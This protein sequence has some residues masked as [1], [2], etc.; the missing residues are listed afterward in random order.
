[1]VPHFGKGVG[2]GGE[3]GLEGGRGVRVG[4]RGGGRGV[5]VGSRGWGVSLAGSFP[6]RQSSIPS[7][8]GV[9]WFFR[10]PSDVTISPAVPPTG[11]SSYIL[12]RAGR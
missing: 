10:F 3:S 6:A 9:P 2:G 4:S 1:M 12:R 11:D 7:N 5:R 8:Y